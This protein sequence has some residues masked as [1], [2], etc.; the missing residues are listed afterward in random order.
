MRQAAETLPNVAV[1]DEAGSGSTMHVLVCT[2]KYTTMWNSSLLFMIKLSEVNAVLHTGT[3]IC[4][5]WSAMPT[6]LP[7]NN[8]K[9]LL[10]S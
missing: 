9:Y 6:Q 2:N 4:K 10:L 8:E 7:Y 5:M 1:P 3:H